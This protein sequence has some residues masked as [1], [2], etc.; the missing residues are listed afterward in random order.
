MANCC[1]TDAKD[2]VGN[3][4]ISLLVWRLPLIGFALG[5]FVSP[6]FRTVLWTASLAVAGVACLVNASRC[7]RMHC[8][9]TGPFFLLAAAVALTHGMGLLPLGSHGWIWIGVAVLVCGCILNFLPERLWGKYATR[10]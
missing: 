2:L 8:Y 5:F 3:K 4:R 7:G 6:N 9:F 10:S 1:A